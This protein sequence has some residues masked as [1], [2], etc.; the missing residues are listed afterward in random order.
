MPAVG[1][2]GRKNPFELQAGH[3]IRGFSIPVHVMDK[4]VIRLAAGGQDYGPHLN[5]VPL[6]LVVEFDGPC[7]A[8]FLAGPALALLQV[9]TLIRIDHV[10]Q[11]NGLGVFHIGRL[12]LGQSRIIFT[13]HLFWTL[14]RAHAAGN[15][16]VHVHVP[17]ILGDPDMEVSLLS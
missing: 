6:G 11:G 17:G 10:F 12:A 4:G 3:D 16:L 8:E 1:P 13:D 9:D 7:R 14:L 15:A 2:R 5:G